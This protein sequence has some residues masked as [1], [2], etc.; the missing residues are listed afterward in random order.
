M[1]SNNKSTNTSS[2]NPQIEPSTQF[3]GVW[4]SAWGGDQSLIEY[5]NKSDFINKINYIL[6]T[7]KSY[8]MNSMIFH[9]RT[10]NDAFYPS[11][12]NPTSP[13][14]SK[15]NFSEF[16]PLEYVIKETHKRGIEFHAWMNPYRV[17]SGNNFDL[18]EIAKSYKNFPKN[19]ANNVS[20]MLKG[21]TTVI[22]NPGL[23]IV[24]NFIIESVLE[25]LNKYKVDA[26]HFD[27][28][29]YCDMGAYGKLSGEN[30]IINEPDQQTYEQYI[31][32]NP[33]CKYD[34]K[35]AENKAD[36]RRLQVDDFIQKLHIA[37][38]NFNIKNS[39]YVQFGISPTG[40][41]KNGDG[42]VNYD[43]KKN[44]ITNGSKTNG[45]QH[46]S[47]YLFC[48]TVK[49]VNNGWIDYI[50]PQSYWAKDHPLAGYENVIGW[51]DKIVKYK[52]VNLYSGIG[53]YMADHTKNT[54][55]W[56]NND[57][58]FYEQLIYVAKSENIKGVSI[59]NFDHLRKYKDGKDTKC[60]TQIKNGLIVW[61]M[62]VPTPEIKSF[63]VIKVKKPENFVVKN[64][65][66]QFDKVKNAKFYVVYKNKNK[67]N[68]NSS[69]IVDIFGCEEEKVSWEDKEKGKFNYGVKALSYSN[70]LGEGSSN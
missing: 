39:Q 2:K 26:I 27:D 4:V 15:V 12:L 62:I 51:W 7:I 17:K 38:K 52:K 33:K 57:K 32:K 65:K 19:P 60:V 21:D 20:N 45:Q 54:Y 53:L 55:G 70:Y 18:N 25:F 28:Y 35:N 42:I 46:Y 10:H 56:K 31:D 64:N 58:Q 30:T 67:V 1:S 43:E 22:L 36:W 50:L 13:Y 61:K 3:R 6:D 29:F 34:K 23:E 59:Y 47:S 5:Q 44:A 16:D 9:V 63:E 49:W 11:E 68:F 14:F 41:Y 24:K 37:I 8:K 69:E 40:I 48:D 66:I